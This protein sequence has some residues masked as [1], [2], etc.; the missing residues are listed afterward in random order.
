MTLKLDNF[1]PKKE[2]Y[3]PLWFKNFKTL[4]QKQIGG[5][6]SALI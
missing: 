6:W 4:K 3:D 1:K 5:V 2:K